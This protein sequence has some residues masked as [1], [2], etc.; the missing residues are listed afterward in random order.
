MASPVSYIVIFALVFKTIPKAKIRWRDVWPGAVVTA[1]LFWLGGSLVGIYLG[2]SV[3]TSVYGAAGSIIAIL[4]WIYYSAW[5]FLFGAKFI[6]L[7][8]D[9]FGAP[10]IPDE[11]TTFVVRQPL[12]TP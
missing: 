7:Y 4:L 1:V 3:W 2:Y 8:A 5:I 11:D 9:K 10:I 12:E 6:K